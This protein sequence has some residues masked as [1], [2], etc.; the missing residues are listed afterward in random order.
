MKRLIELYKRLLEI[1]NEKLAARKYENQ[2]LYIGDEWHSLM[3]EA[4][5]IRQKSPLDWEKF[6]MIFENYNKV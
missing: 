6:L 3:H 4:L 5:L 1:R 2:I